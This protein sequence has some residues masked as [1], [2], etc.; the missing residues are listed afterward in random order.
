MHRFTYQYP[1]NYQLCSLTGDTHSLITP[2]HSIYSLQVRSLIG[3]THSL[4]G[5]SP[6]VT[7]SHLYTSHSHYASYLTCPALTLSH[8]YLVYPILNSPFPVPLLLSLTFT[9]SSHCPALILLYR[10]H[11]PSWADLALSHFCYTPTSPCPALTT[12][13]L[14]PVP[15]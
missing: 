11:I 14:Y 7:V 15:P 12:P 4:T 9:P 6:S 3:Y 8:F 5:Y 13:H 2:T 10:Y 1:L